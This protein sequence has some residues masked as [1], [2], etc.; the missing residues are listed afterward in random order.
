[1]NDLKRGEKVKD[2]KGYE[3]IYAVTSHGR[4]WSIKRKI[5]LA[6]FLTGNGYKTV[7]LS[8]FGEE[9]DK[10]VHRLVGEAFIPNPVNKPQINH[11]NGNKLDCNVRNLE[12]MTAR[13][14]MQHAG[15]NGLNKT[16]KFSYFD[17]ILI[18]KLYHRLKLKKAHL[19]KLFRVTPPAISYIIKEYSDM[20][21]A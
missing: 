19:A 5:W 17:K 14:N 15:D 16:F 3:G 4:I 9:E 20:A 10:K 2:I 21:L 13:E 12:W 18:C 6:P 11:K 7:R 1:M 8:H